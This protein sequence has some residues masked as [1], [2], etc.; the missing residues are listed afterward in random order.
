MAEWPHCDRVWGLGT[1]NEPTTTWEIT[2][3]LL[4]PRPVSRQALAA[5][6]T[7]WESVNPDD[8]SRTYVPF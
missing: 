2:H 1:R 4:R 8:P 7:L 3:V 6:N 5:A